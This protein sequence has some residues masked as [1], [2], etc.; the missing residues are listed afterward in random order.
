M[1]RVMVE[2]F[3]SLFALGL[4]DILTDDDVEFCGSGRDGVVARLRR[5]V[6]DVV[7]LNSAL[8]TTPEVVAQLVHHH[9]GITVITCSSDE[10]VMRVYPAH[11]SG[12]SFHRP[13]EATEIG[14]QVHGASAGRTPND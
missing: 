13:L 10:H 1:S 7:L 14:R 5:T 12:E 4:R 11:H 3:D 9:P 2:G 6:P 8:P